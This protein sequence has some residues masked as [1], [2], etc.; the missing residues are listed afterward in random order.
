METINPICDKCIHLASNNNDGLMHGCRAFPD[1]IPNSI[2]FSNKH[3]KKHKFQ[4]GDFIYT[5]IKAI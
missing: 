4:K 1:G 3:N 5:P 2:L